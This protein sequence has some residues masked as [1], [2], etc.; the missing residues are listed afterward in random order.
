M[1]R[2]LLLISILGCFFSSDLSAQEIKISDKIE[3]QNGKEYYLHT[4]QNGET[5]W[6]IAKAY[7]VSV[8]DVLSVNPES[9]KG[10]KPGQLLKV[11]VKNKKT[12]YQNHTVEKGE[13]LYKIAKKYNVSVESIEEVNKDLAEKIQPGQ[14]LKIPVKPA[15]KTTQ[16]T[17]T[18][19]SDTATTLGNANEN[20][21]CNKPKLLE[22][23]NIALMIPFYLSQMYQVK[24]DDPDIEEK[25]Q[26]DY[27]SFTFIQFY[28]GI[29]IAL[30]S[31][32]KTGFSAKVYVYD[33]DEDSS[34]IEAI[35]EKP[36]MAKMNLIIGPFF[37]NSLKPVVD[38]AKK[39]NIKV[40]DPVSTDE[41]ILNGNPNVFKATP[42]V[43]SQFNDV[44]E[45]FVNAYPTATIILAHNNNENELRYLA[46]LKEALNIQYKKTGKPEN[47]FKEAIVS[48]IGVGGIT[49]LFN[50]SDTNIVLTLT[51]GEVFVT[52]YVR[53]LSD[54]FDS[55]KMIVVGLPSW[56]N[57]ENIEAEYFQ[58]I[59]L[60][61]FSSSFIDYSRN[62]V[63]NFILKYREKY[64][65]EPNKY[66]F[67]GFDIG[68]IF[69][70]ALKIYGT[71]FEKCI[72]QLSGSYLQSKYSFSNADRN[73]G[74]ENQELN[75]YRYFD[76]Q[77][78]DARTSKLGLTQKEK[79]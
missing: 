34:K 72:D 8:E 15:N 71:S 26:D 48:Q 29:L 21:N 49:K 79:K 24:P 51:N 59:N 44:A 46:L 62:D 56:K 25:D 32:K 30:D 43:T 54:V 20:Y 42:S 41:E 35:L 60:H 19:V 47:S 3:K 28:E 6:K 17:L 65:T 78:F 63:K 7:S 74:F 77:L 64:Q 5:V 69:F 22:S 12:E 37:K 33:V 9:S 55:Y 16:S 58:K 67:Q 11:I 61:L 73:N 2:F 14:V 40:I 18:T 10:I 4:V 23:Y 38:Y 31:L 53:N 75:I 68:M 13:S 66:A 50:P 70:K 27:A 36:E 76:Y 52:N 39:H 45:Y 1:K 57:Y